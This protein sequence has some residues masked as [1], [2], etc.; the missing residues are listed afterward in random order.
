VN[1]S[2]L[3]PS[4]FRAERRVL[5]IQTKL[6]R[7]ANDDPD[8]RFDDLYNLVTDPG[9]LMMAWERVAGNKGARS[10]GVDGQTVGFVR[11]RIGVD[12]FLAEL[13]EQLTSR[14]FRPLPVKERMIPKPGSQKRRRLGIPTVAD[15]VVQASLKLVLEPI[16]EADFAP[17]SYG[18]RPNRRAH[19][20]IAETRFLASKT[21]EWVLEGDIAACFDEISHPALMDLVRARIGDKSVLALVK[22]FLKAGIL[23]QGGASKD[24]VTGTPQ[25]GILSPLLANVALSVLDEHFAKILG[26]PQTSSKRRFTRRQKG[27]PNYRLIRYADD[28]VILV[29]GTR[30]HTEAL[31]PEVAEVLSTVGLRLSVEKTLIT[32]IDEGLDFLG[33]RIQRHRKRGTDRHY[34]YNYPAKKALR[35]IKAKCKAICRTNV[36]LPL[37]V[38]LHKLNQV[39]RGWT[40]YFRPG[41]SA[42]AFQYL[43][44]VVWRQV[45]GWLRRKHLNTA[46]KELRRR[47]CGGGWWPHE[48]T[49]VL[50]NPG[51]VV[52]TRYRP[53]GTTIPSPWPSA[54]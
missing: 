37:A 47:Y 11:D 16:F 32:H 26:G 9:F 34:V 50:F 25:G 17:C 42:R 30:A 29:S 46:W 38:L 7:W 35:S 5:E 45:F 24:T 44:M 49:V 15:R 54:T 14:S 3:A 6:H 51:S 22:A 36:S 53:R 31:L 8:R 10:A 19:D 18:F 40:T 39:L 4:S 20:A 28:F 48:G 52:T 2:D 41:V 27:L 21:Y 43:R 12:N 33:W 1:T 13:R 23:T